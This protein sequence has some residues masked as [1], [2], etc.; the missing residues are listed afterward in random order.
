MIARF[1]DLKTI[2]VF[3]YSNTFF[4][5]IPQGTSDQVQLFLAC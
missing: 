1:Y 2:P 5:I 4:V 3:I